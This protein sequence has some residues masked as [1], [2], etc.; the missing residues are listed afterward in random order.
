MV[1]SPFYDMNEFLEGHAEE[2]FEFFFGGERANEVRYNPREIRSMLTDPSQNL[3]ELGIRR[4][5][6]FGRILAL[7]SVAQSD[8]QGEPWRQQKDRART[9]LTEEVKILLSECESIAFILNLLV[10][11]EVEFHMSR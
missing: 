6:R 2:L 9:T 8:L 7:S 4:Y 3:T 10:F 1:V 11:F 5:R